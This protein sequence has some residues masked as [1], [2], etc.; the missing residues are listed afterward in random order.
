[1]ESLKIEFTISRVKGFMLYQTNNKR[2]C[3]HTERE[4]GGKEGTDKIMLKYIYENAQ[5]EMS[6]DS[7]LCM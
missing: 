7:Y 6:A 1:M 5:L 2:R 4:R 3:L